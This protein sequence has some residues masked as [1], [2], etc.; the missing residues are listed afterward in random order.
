MNTYIQIIH[1]YIP[2]CCC[3]VASVVSDSVRPHRQQPARLLCPWDSPGKKTG[4][5]CHFLLQGIFP[6][7]RSDLCLLHGQADSLPRATGEAQRMVQRFLKSL[8]IELPYDPAIPLLGIY[9]ER[10]KALIQEDNMHPNVHS[11]TV[12][13]R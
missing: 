1:L 4:V 8:K 12:Y 5:G 3:Q 9:P 11:S 7:Q 13:T 10:T 2:C 6:T